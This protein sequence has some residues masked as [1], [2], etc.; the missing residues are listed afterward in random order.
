MSLHGEGPNL[1]HAQVTQMPV[2]TRLDVDD[3]T[4]LATFQIPQICELG[5]SFDHPEFYMIWEMSIAVNV[6]LSGLELLHVH[7][8]YQQADLIQALRCL[9][10][11]KSLIIGNGSDLDADCFGEFVPK[12]L[13]ETAAFMQ[14]HNGG[15]VSAVLCPMLRSLLI[16]E[17]D[18]TQRRE[19]MPVFNFRRVVTLR[20][21]WGSPLEE[22]TLFDFELGRMTKLVGSQG[23]FVMKTIVLGRGTQRF[24]LDI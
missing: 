4:L 23:I 10:A 21:V 6:N 13:N 17:C 2:C 1:S 16:E 18:L 9:P 22:F 14:S 24:R 19:L 15:Q 12:P 8:W 20:A 5:A 11:L 3:L 7:G